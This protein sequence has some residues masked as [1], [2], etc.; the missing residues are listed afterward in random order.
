ML[1]F[2]FSFKCR[3]K[4]DYN[5]GIRECNFFLE[6]SSIKLVQVKKVD[7]VEIRNVLL[8][9]PNVVCGIGQPTATGERFRGPGAAGG[10]LD[11]TSKRPSPM[12]PNRVT[13]RPFT[14]SACNS[15]ESGNYGIAHY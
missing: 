2:F 15:L 10:R 13:I 9:F 8:K 3:H 6:D 11:S 5:K 7:F 1:C 12:P 14:E 4:D